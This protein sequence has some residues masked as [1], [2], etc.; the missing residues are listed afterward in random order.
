MSSMPEQIKKALLET[1]AQIPQRILWKYENELEDIPKNMMIRKWLPQRDILCNILWN[2]SA[3][4]TIEVT[5]K[6]FFLSAPK[7]E[8]IHQSRRCIWDIRNRGR[9]SPSSWIS[10]VW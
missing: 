4:F 1:F 9:W 3:N 7:C 10:L 6:C 2:K 8:T 5:L